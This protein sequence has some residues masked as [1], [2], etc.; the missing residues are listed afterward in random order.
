MAAND[1]DAV[2][3][4]PTDHHGKTRAYAAGIS[5]NARWIRCVIRHTKGL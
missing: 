2:G 4:C 5:A 1:S 3:A